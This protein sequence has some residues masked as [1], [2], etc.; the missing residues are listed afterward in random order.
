MAGWFEKDGSLERIRPFNS[1]TVLEN[2]GER[3]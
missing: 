1:S 3:S 2:G